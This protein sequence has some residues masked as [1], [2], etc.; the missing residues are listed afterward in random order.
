MG[1]LMLSKLKSF[2]SIKY[3][4][5]Y[6]IVFVFVFC[7]ITANSNKFWFNNNATPFVHD[8]KM[9]YSYLPK[10]FIENDIEYNNKQDYW[11][12][13]LPNGRHIMKF[14]CGV[15]ILAAPFFLL[16]WAYSL[17]ASIPVDPY[18]QTFIEFVHY[19]DFLYFLLALICIR[20]TLKYYM[21]SELAISICILSVFFG[22]NLYY[23]ILGQTFMSHGFLFSLHAVFIY[24]CIK[25]YNKINITNSILVGLIGGLITLI[26]PVEILCFLVWF[27]WE[28]SSF[29][30]I[31]TRILLLLNKWTYLLIMLGTV[32]LVFLP[33]MMYWHLITGNF[34]VYSYASGE[35][36]FFNDPKIIGVLLGYKSGMFLYS[37]I[38]IIYFICLLFVEF[39]NRMSFLLFF[40]LTVYVVSCWWCWWYGGTYGMRALIQVYPYLIIPFGF[41][42]NKLFESRIKWKFAVNVV[43]LLFIFSLSAFQIKNYSLLKKG[44]VHYDS[45]SK[46]SYWFIFDKF[47]ING[48]EAQLYFKMLKAPDYNKA[49]LGERDF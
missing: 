4:S 29:H 48:D 15:A 37:P 13:P 8:S 43:V 5:V 42:L 1:Y 10:F 44:F 14:T 16:A 32:I 6:T 40:I 12:E 2:L 31:K 9:Y 35:R 47:N 39:K 7:L 49:K 46:E 41:F 30:D 28:V 24:L 26:R 25:F 45:M 23:Y 20:K 11:L 22:T 34:L 19:G 21:I 38:T 36:L 17:I 18:S 33:Q 27:L 3:I